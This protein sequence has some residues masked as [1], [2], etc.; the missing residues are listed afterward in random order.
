ME[1]NNQIQCKNGTRSPLHDQPSKGPRS[2]DRNRMHSN[3]KLE[4]FCCCSSATLKRDLLH[5]DL[6]FPSTLPL[7]LFP[8]PRHTCCFH[9]ANATNDENI[10]H[11]PPKPKPSVVFA[12]PTH[13]TRLHPQSRFKTQFKTTKDGEAGG[14]RRRRTWIRN[15]RQHRSIA[16]NKQPVKKGTSKKTKGSLSVD[17]GRRRK[18][19]EAEAEVEVEVDKKRRRRGKRKQT[20]NSSCCCCSS[21]SC[22]C[23]LGVS[24][25]FALIMAK[26]IE[27]NIMEYK[28][29]S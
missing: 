26:P 24:F 6:P 9:F 27:R 8:F 23:C 28:P 10:G 12:L 22:S 29:A 25:P 11:T 15:R 13:P 7:P 20:Q 17:R 21:S 18:E 19:V 16:N 4:L 2:Q 3:H 14:R 1:N 5:H